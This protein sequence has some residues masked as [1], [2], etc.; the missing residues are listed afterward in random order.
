MRARPGT[1][2][3]L[4]RTMEVTGMDE[5]WLLLDSRGPG[6]IETH[7]AELAE[8]LA[9]AGER[10][11]VLFLQDHGPHPLRARLAA[12]GIPQ[13]AL[14][15]GF[16]PLAR[17]LRAVRPRLLHTHGYKANLLGR[18]A[19]RLARVRVVASFH[20]GERPGGRVA[21]WDAADRWTACLGGRIAVSEPIR[22]RLPWGAELVPNFVAI[23]PEPP[24]SRPPVVAFVGRLSAEK[25]PDIFCDVAHRLPSLR[26]EAFGDG[27]LRAS[28]EAQAGGRVHFHGARPGMEGAWAGIGLL[29]ITSRAEGMPLA[30]LEAMAHGVPVAAFGLGALPGL[31]RHGVDGF[32]AAP[33]DIAALSDCIARWAT[34]DQAERDAMGR[35]AREAVAARHGR[36]A[37][38]ARMR[39][40]Y[41][42]L[43]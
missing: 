8:G 26:F 41:V 22:A 43:A 32:L 15:G 24:R 4:T 9:E 31:I 18:L 35:H 1:P 17:R 2:H 23:P 13:E 11:R 39:E 6:G 19:A 21:L 10:P 37:G 27:S 40:A 16:A 29:A 14:A 25:G 7:V 30:A 12:S 3:A 36:A 5:T 38:I 42:R 34:L 28:C 20:A 33:G